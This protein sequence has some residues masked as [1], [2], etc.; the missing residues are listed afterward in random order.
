MRGCLSRSTTIITTLVLL[1]DWTACKNHAPDVEPRDYLEK[2][3]SDMAKNAPPSTDQKAH[4]K[5]QRIILGI[6]QSASQKK[7]YKVEPTEGADLGY[8]A[9]PEIA[10]LLEDPE[11]WVRLSTMAVLFQLDYKRSLP[12]LVG[13]LPDMARFH[14][15]DED[16]W[17]DFTISSQAAGYLASVCHEAP[18]PVSVKEMGQPQAETLAQQR[19]YTYHLPYCSW[20]EFP[21]EEMRWLDSLALYSHV[22]DDD[23]VARLKSEP[24]KFKYVPVVRLLLTSPSMIFSKGQPIEGHL[25]YENLGTE[26]FQWGEH[27][28]KGT[29]VL[30]LVGPDGRDIPARPKLND[31]MM[32]AITPPVPPGLGLS[33][34]VN[35]A[36]AYDVSRAGYYRFYYSYLPTKTWR[37]SKFEQT[38]DLRCW[39]GR[40][41]ANHCDFVVK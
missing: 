39:D 8:Q 17:E 34:Y 21:L 23:L 28:A 32:Q 24:E 31:F 29:H 40:E 6:H 12:F 14:Y 22:P 38:L 4:E 35:L 25:T 41:Y 9:F 37:R 20:R 3:F 2:A 30:R 26:R 13:M 15:F 36:A 1:W 16:V 5:V 7:G 18:V 27:P 33:F 10:P 19:W 11:P